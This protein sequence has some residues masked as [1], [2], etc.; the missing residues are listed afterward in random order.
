M[1]KRIQ[2]VSTL[3]NRV[4]VNAISRVTLGDSRLN[5]PDIVISGKPISKGTPIGIDLIAATIV[6]VTRMTLSG[7]ST[8]SDTKTR[9]DAATAK[10]HETM[11]RENEAT[12]VLGECMYSL[13]ES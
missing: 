3:I 8:R 7:T 10:T 4:P 12:I 11:L 6:V 1:K 9:Y 5:K 13:N 2:R